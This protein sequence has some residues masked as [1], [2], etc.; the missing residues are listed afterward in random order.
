M[1]NYF[2]DTQY[3]LHSNVHDVLTILQTDDPI[4]AISILYNASKDRLPV[5]YGEVGVGVE[6]IAAVFTLNANH[7]GEI[8]MD[9][10]WQFWI[11]YIGCNFEIVFHF[12]FSSRGMIHTFVSLTVEISMVE[13]L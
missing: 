2:V 13:L 8:K 10:I 7:M 5:V 6:W 3:I 1:D 4:S 12:F 11:Q 9:K